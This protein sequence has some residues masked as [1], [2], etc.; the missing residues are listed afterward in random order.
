MSISTLPPASRPA[1][2][3]ARRGGNSGG[4][5]LAKRLRARALF[6]LLRDSTACAV[7][8]CPTIAS[9]LGF[10]APQLAAAV[11]NLDRD[12]LVD[13]WSSRFGVLVRLR[14]GGQ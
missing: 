6:F 3:R 11:N 13:V 2:A 10:T 14:R 1:P 12:G 9:R 5:D 4:S 8:V 7:Q